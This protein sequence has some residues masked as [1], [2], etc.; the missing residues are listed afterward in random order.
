MKACGVEGTKQGLVAF[1]SQSIHYVCRFTFKEQM[2]KFVIALT[3]T[4]LF[5]Q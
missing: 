3:R 4:V 5:Q 1:T 2:M